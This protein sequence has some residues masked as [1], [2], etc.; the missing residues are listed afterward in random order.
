MKIYLRLI[1]ILLILSAIL[2]AFTSCIENI[3]MRNPPDDTTENIGGNGSGDGTGDGTGDADGYGSNVSGQHGNVGTVPTL[4]G[5]DPY[6]NVSKNAF[7]SN[8]TTASSYEDAYYRTEN[9][10]PAYGNR[11]ASPA[12]NNGQCRLLWI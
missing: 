8:Y 1:S 2:G 7:Y 12:S 3:G 5:N 10:L 6:E 4:S 9:G 11:C